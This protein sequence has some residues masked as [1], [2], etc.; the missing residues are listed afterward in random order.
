MDATILSFW[1]NR[2]LT[3]RSTLRENGKYRNALEKGDGLYSLKFSLHDKEWEI[4]SVRRQGDSKEFTIG[5]ITDYGKIE[6]LF[7]LLR[8]IYA[9]IE[10]RDCG[11]VN[12]QKLNT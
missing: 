7:P 6:F 2:T 12:I 10:E 5:D 8:S 9:D 11:S 3:C 4:L 1:R